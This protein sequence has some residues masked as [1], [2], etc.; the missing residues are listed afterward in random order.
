MGKVPRLSVSRIL[1][2]RNLS[3][4]SSLITEL[5]LERGHLDSDCK[6]QLPLQVGFRQRNVLKMY[7][8]NF[9]LIS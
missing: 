9:S 4:C 8:C 6:S 5:P 7:V 3:S 1:V 2:H